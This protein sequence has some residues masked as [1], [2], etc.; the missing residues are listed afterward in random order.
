MYDCGVHTLWH[1]K[2][3]IELGVV[4]ESLDSAHELR[5]TD[6]MVGKRLRLAQEL[7]DERLL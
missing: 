2:H 7:W 1:L 3:I 4:H 6:D 5:F